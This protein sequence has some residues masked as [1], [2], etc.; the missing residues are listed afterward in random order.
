ME[1][2][3]ILL[4]AFIG[5]AILA[6][7]YKRRENAAH[8]VRHLVVAGAVGALTWFVAQQVEAI[9]DVALLISA[10]AALLVY[11]TRPRRGRYIRA[12]VKRQKIAEWQLRTGKKFNPRTH[13]LDH[14]VPFSQGGSHTA[15]N[16]EV[17][18]KKRNRS[19]GARSEWWDLLGR[20]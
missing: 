16:L 2:L 5:L 12:S 4:W 9:R 3:T 20:R 1:N 7:I 13:E 6:G 17:V 15:D 11:A 18:E 14:I 10:M 19:K 8:N